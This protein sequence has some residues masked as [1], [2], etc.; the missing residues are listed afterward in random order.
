MRYAMAKCE[1]CQREYLSGGGYDEGR[2]AECRHE[3]EKPAVAGRRA[4]VRGGGVDGSP[5][6]PHARGRGG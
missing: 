3:A 2:C 1:T 6:R 5:R 4:L